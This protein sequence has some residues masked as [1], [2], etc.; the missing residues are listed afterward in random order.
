MKDVTSRAYVHGLD[1]TLENEIEMPASARRRLRRQHG[2]HVALLHVHVVHLPDDRSSATTS[3]RGRARCSARRRF[4]VSTP[5]STRPSRSSSRARTDAK[6]PM[7]LVHK[8]GL[9]ARRQQPDA[10]VRL[11]R[12]QHR[13]HARVQLAAHRVA[14]AGLRLRQ[15][16][17]ARRQ[18]VRRGLA[19]RGHEAARSRTSSTT[20]SPRPSG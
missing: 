19:R 18:R 13:H 11:R 12:L 20:S 14:R 4:P 1:G 17:H 2:R 5:T 7:F 6:V 10:D 9:A 16:Q 8:K 3:R 15:R